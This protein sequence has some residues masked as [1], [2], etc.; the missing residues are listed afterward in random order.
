MDWE[1]MLPASAALVAAI[2]YCFIGGGMIDSPQVV[3]NLFIAP[4]IGIVA[5]KIH[6]CIGG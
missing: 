1:G 2:I 3:I 6:S 4:I 5:F